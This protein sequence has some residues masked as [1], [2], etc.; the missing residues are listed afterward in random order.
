[1][2]ISAASMLST[3]AP[4]W[5]NSTMSAIQANK[6][7]GGM[8]GALDASRK[9]NSRK[10][11]ANVANSFALIAQNNVSNTSSFYAQLASQ[12]IQKR[13]D[14]V[15]EQVLK[16]LSRSHNMVKPKNVLDPTIF[17]ADGSTL[18]TTTNIMTMVTG[19]QYDVTT[20]A[21]Y[22]DPAFIVQMANGSYL[23]TQTN[24]LTMTDGTQID[25]VTGLKVSQ[26]DKTA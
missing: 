5:I 10:T 20:G 19:K 6:T 2:A 4:D 12:A 1:M 9:G 13:Q 15:M 23:N 25:T 7:M 17:F 24:V 16:E 14:K 8:M 18:N 22:I 21:E 3:G 11:F 26:L